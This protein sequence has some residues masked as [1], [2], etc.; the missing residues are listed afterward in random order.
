M[1]ILSLLISTSHLK[2]IA[3][4]AHK[5]TMGFLRAGQT[6]MNYSVLPPGPQSEWTAPACFM[7]GC[8]VGKEALLIRL[9]SHYAKK[10]KLLDYRKVGGE[11]DESASETL[12]LQQLAMP[13]TQNAKRTRPST[14]TLLTGQG[15]TF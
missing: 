7:S 10:L 4:T 15:M 11:S 2:S 8:P 9:E 14:H 6:S 12:S 5:P 13:A 3:R 1:A